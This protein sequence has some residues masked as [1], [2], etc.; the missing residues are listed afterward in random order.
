MR[1]LSGLGAAWDSLEA[2]AEVLERQ[3]QSIGPASP[4]YANLIAQARGLRQQ[5]H[6]LRDQAGYSKSK[7][8]G[9]FTASQARPA[10]APSATPATSGKSQYEIYAEETTTQDRRVPAAAV[11]TPAD[12][13]NAAYKAA[14]AGGASHEEAVEIGQRAADAQRAGVTSDSALTFAAQ[15]A[16]TIQPYKWVATPRERRSLLPTES[17]V[18]AAVRS[19]LQMPA[20]ST[21]AKVTAGA[22]LAVGLTGLVLLGIIYS[23]R[24]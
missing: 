22:A 18:A 9:M 21:G 16:A 17:P 14:V 7:E 3:A 23:M 1:S 24:D 5:A 20:L 12:A 15:P 11:K 19:P 13:A 4:A 8:P 2:Q 6:I 10:A